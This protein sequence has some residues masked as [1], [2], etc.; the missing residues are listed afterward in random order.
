MTEIECFVCCYGQHTGL[1]Q[2][3]SFLRRL[4]SSLQSA[5]Q[6]LFAVTNSETV[7]P[8]GL[9]IATTI[10]INSNPALGVQLVLVAAR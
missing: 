7:F 6:I 5:F 3:Q 10:L 9:R 4:Y 2:A 8:V 1:G